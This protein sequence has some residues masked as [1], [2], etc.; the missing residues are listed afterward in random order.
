MPFIVSCLAGWYS[1][2]GVCMKAFEAEVGLKYSEA[3]AKCQELGADLAMPHNEADVQT[4]TILLLNFTAGFTSKDFWIGKNL[5][6]V[7][8]IRWQKI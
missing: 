3:A 8:V 7:T 6:F 4:M 5:C 2:Q 1:S